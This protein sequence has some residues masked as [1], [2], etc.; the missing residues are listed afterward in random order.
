VDRLRT[1]SIHAFVARASDDHS[2]AIPNVESLTS[3]R[4]FVEMMK[5]SS[6]G[7]TVVAITRQYSGILWIGVCRTGQLEIDYDSATWQLAWGEC[8][9]GLT[10]ALGSSGWRLGVRSILKNRYIP[11]VW[12]R[13][14]MLIRALRLPT[15]CARVSYDRLYR[16]PELRDDLG[17]TM[18]H[19]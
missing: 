1:L 14:R 8:A 17:P 15:W 11:F 7:G 10:E 18:V 4:D 19:V 9:R 12:L 3:L 16:R 13:H 5:Q 6:L 2:I